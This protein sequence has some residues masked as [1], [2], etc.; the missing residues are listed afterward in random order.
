MSNVWTDISPIVPW[1]KE[2]VD[3][4]TQKPKMLIKRII[5][6]FSNE[7]DLVLDCFCGSGTVGI[8]AK[9]INR[10]FICNDINEKYINI[11]MN[12]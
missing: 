4:P 10:N 3:H 7:N 12:R 6:I 9:E 1:S 2:R 8:V 11:A 5:D